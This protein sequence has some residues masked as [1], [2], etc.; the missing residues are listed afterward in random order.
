[1][2]RVRYTHHARADLL[3]IWVRIA[4]HDEATANRIVDT[5][6]QRCEQLGD[7]PELGPARPEIAPGGRALVTGRWLVLYRILAASVQ[8]VRVVDGAS[9][10][11]LL[12]LP[13]SR[14]P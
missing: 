8:I 12:A 4:A 13:E 6:T 2:S 11:S 3:D 10:L 14:E 5:I 7:F 1:M 9:D